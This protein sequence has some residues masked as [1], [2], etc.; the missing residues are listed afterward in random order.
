VGGAPVTLHGEVLSRWPLGGG[1]KAQVHVITG[2]F[3]DRLVRGAIAGLKRLPLLSRLL[4][5]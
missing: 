2:R 1:E 3:T 4:G 5:G